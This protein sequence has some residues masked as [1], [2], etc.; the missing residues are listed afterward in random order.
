MAK[1]I[2]WMSGH[3]EC[4]SAPSP[5]SLTACDLCERTT[6]AKHKHWHG[7]DD[8]TCLADRNTSSIRAWPNSLDRRLPR[9]CIAPPLLQKKTKED[10]ISEVLNPPYPH[11]FTLVSLSI[12]L[13]GGIP[14]NIN[15]AFSKEYG[16][17]HKFKVFLG[18]QKLRRLCLQ[19][20]PIPQ[21][22][23]LVGIFCRFLQQDG[24]S[25]S[26]QVFK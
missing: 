15:C 4:C 26:L 23:F 10:F 1:W 2:E 17:S 8:N 12:F 16:G 19:I 5:H 14:L 11:I 25:F 7:W 3:N 18:Y 13:N 21:T 24:S 20:F 9:Y 6:F 22:S